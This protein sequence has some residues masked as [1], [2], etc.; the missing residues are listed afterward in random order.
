MYHKNMYTMR[1]MIQKPQHLKNS[2]VIK[3]CEEKMK[4]CHHMTS[5]A[6][7][8]K[9][10][11]LKKWMTD[12]S[13]EINNI[14]IHIYLSKTGIHA[15]NRRSLLSIC[16]F[17]CPSRSLP[18][19]CVQWHC[20]QTNMAISVHSHNSIFAHAREECKRGW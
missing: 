12:I 11:Y 19:V 18:G 8:R 17:C 7:D 16:V 10:Q 1:K 15:P 9:I 2:L 13:L 4:L 20:V 5:F 3:T 14:D 6:M